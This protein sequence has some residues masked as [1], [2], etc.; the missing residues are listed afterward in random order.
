[1]IT[2]HFKDPFLKIFK[3]SFESIVVLNSEGIFVFWFWGDGPKSF[4]VNVFDLKHTLTFVAP[5]NDPNT[6]WLNKVNTFKLTP[7][8]KRMM[9]FL[10]YSRIMSLSGSL[11]SPSVI[12]TRTLV[13]SGETPAV[14][15][16]KS[17]SLKQMIIEN[18]EHQPGLE[19]ST[20]WPCDQQ[21]GPHQTETGLAAYSTNWS[22]LWVL[23]RLRMCGSLSS[24]SSALPSS[25]SLKSKTLLDQ[26]ENWT[27]ANW[28]SD[29]VTERRR[30]HGHN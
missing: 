28:R 1:M 30:S 11:G 9:F 24:A 17:F 3:N 27:A 16:S 4:Y 10:S 26:L 19:T 2:F 15:F 20:K 6:L 13:E 23:V 22:A 5:M 21:D 14:L 18:S 7:M 29:K 12:R 8:T 25:Y